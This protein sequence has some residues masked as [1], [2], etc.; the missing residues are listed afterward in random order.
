MAGHE[1]VWLEGEEAAVAVAPGIDED[2][3]DLAVAITGGDDA[4]IAEAGIFHV[5][6]DGEGLE[7][8][9]VGKRAFADLDEI[10]EV[11]GGAQAGGI[12]TLH[13]VEAVCALLA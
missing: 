2:G 6:V 10:G 5:N 4:A 9:P 3:L 8:L 13:Q 7:P 1:Q 12:H 11:E